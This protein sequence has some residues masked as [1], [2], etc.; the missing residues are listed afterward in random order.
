MAVSRRPRA[1]F[2][3]EDGINLTPLLD[4]IFN[5]IFFFILA[6]SINELASL[7]IKLPKADVPQIADSE[8]RALTVAIT[9]DGR[10]VFQGETLTRETLTERIRDAAAQGNVAG[11]VIRGDRDSRLQASI[12]AMMACRDAGVTQVQMDMDRSRPAP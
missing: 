6:T 12:D 2:A 1:R 3:L 5:L 11:V 10:I 8:K 4:M 7:D 9:Q